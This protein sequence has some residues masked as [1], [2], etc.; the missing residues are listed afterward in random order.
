MGTS[1]PAKI[2]VEAEVRA[3]VETVWKYFTEPDHITKWNHA[4]DDWHSPYA[5]ND[6]TAGGKFVF[7]ME[8]KDGSFGFDFSG[9]YDEVRVHEKISYT[10]GDDR[11][12]DVTF[13]SQ[14]DETKV[15][16]TFEAET[17]HS[18]E[19]QQAGWQAILNS[20]KNYTEASNP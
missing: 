9:T 18:S 17:T 10:M 13:I 4:S 5:E 2:T 3:P 12:V 14:G 11:K 1:Q 7:R 15:I 19:M 16:E 6:L 20:F 8:A